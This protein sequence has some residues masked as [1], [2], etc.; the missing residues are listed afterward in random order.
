M[1]RRG[2]ERFRKIKELGAGSFGVTLL[3]EDQSR[4]GRHVVI[5]VPLNEDT[6]TAIVEDFAKNQVLLANLA[7]IDHPNL[8]K[9]LGLAKYDGHF[10]MIMEYVNGSDLR[11]LIGPCH[12][13]RRPQDLG[14]VLQTTEAV[15]SGLAAVHDAK[16]M[17][18]DIKPENILVREEDDLAKL[19]DFGLGTVVRSLST[20][21]VAAVG[22][23]YPYMAP[24]VFSGK[25]GFASDVWAMSVMLYELV[26]GR[27]PFWGNDQ[28]SLREKITREEP[29]P[30]AGHNFRVDKQL[31]D[32]ILQGL[33]KDHHR[34]YRTGAEMLKAVKAYRRGAIVQ[35][36]LVVG[37]TERARDLFN[38]G[39]AA[40][41]EKLL[42]EL[43]SSR[44]EN[45]PKVHLALA[46]LYSRSH[47]PRQAES[48]LRLGIKYCPDD[49]RLHRYLAMVLDSLRPVPGSKQREEAIE[50]L[51][52][53]INL[54]LSKKQDEDARALLRKWK[55]SGGM[56]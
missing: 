50:A 49:A 31:N 7:E 2:W 21:M 44:F 30:P 22:G 6:E 18:G 39:N 34:R 45:V 15:C 24:E 9:C 41:A 20:S 3:V 17:H 5:K 14:W 56:S 32:L 47:R 36:E 48:A 16:L 28:D 53:A 55:G 43:V 10:V 33:E 11:Q 42:Q 46:E 37:H 27:M 52:K 29:V 26:T 13:A 23:T 12:Q 19:T 38:A 4:D 51:Q 25:A 35:D 40:D 1:F 54:G 8:V